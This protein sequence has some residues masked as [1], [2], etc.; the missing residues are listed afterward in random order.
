MKE[1]IR[2]GVFETNSS[3]VHTLTLKKDAS[4]ESF[5]TPDLES[6][7]KENGLMI[8]PRSEGWQY[9]NK[10]IELFELKLNELVTDI[11]ENGWGRDGYNL[12]YILVSFANRFGIRVIM[13]PDFD[14]IPGEYKFSG[15]SRVL[16][17]YEDA[18]LLFL[19]D[20]NNKYRTFDKNLWYSD[21]NKFNTPHGYELLAEDD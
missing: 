5:I 9:P 13:T 17:I 16:P 6:Y 7:L 21:E 19:L 11:F 15:I 2:R 8:G 1:T 10:H 18:V 12:F 4:Y 20:D 14:D 3:S